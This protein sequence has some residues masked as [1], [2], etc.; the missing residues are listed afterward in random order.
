[1]E[2]AFH[3]VVTGRTVLW[4]HP[5]AVLQPEGLSAAHPPA[6][7]SLAPKDQ[8]CNRQGGRGLQGG[9]RTRGDLEK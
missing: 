5:T 6:I 9:K 7:C 4:R 3:T 2:R 1:M 8:G